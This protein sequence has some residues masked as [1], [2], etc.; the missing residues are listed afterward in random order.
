MAKISI[1]LDE[2]DVQ[3][4][5]RR[6]RSAHRGNLSAAVAEGIRLARHQEAMGALLD[7]LGA[8]TL[9]AS[10]IQA[11]GRELDGEAKPTRRGPR[12]GRAA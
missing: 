9:T 7:S 12:G 11:L 10:E 3:W 4:L 6:A 8:P 5:Q 2:H 1:S